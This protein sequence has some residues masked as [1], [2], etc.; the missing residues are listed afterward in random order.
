MLE[1]TGLRSAILLLVGGVFAVGCSAL[2]D[3]DKAKLGA[4][5]GGDTGKCSPKC[6]DGIDCTIDECGSDNRCRYRP[7]AEACD[8]G[9]GC[10]EDVCDPTRGCTNEESD[11]RCEFC[12]PGSTCNAKAGGCVGFKEQRDC[13]D[14]DPCTRTP[15]SSRR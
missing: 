5:T 2:I 10:T 13:D 7:A 12:A 4:S 1:S 11:E 3:T 14:D 9:I 8:D 15:V 6:D